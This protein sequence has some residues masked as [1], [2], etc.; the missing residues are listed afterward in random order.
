MK[1]LGMKRAIRFPKVL[2]FLAVMLM[3]A[4]RAVPAEENMAADGYIFRW[5]GGSGKA[6]IACT[7]VGEKDGRTEVTLVFSGTKGR[8]SHYDTVRVDGTDYSGNNEFTIPV[9]LN[10]NTEI[11]ARTTAMSQPHWIDYTIYVGEAGVGGNGADRSTLNDQTET[12]DTKAPDIAGLSFRS[13]IGTGN[14]ELLKLFRYADADE[15]LYTL[16]EADMK[17]RTAREDADAGEAGKTTGEDPD[18][19][20]LS[21]EEA[22]AAAAAALKKEMYDNSVVKYLIIP[23]GKEAPAGLDREVII[24]SRPLEHVYAASADALAHMEEMELADRI[25][26]VGLHEK[27]I[28]SDLIREKMTEGTIVPG[29]PADDPDYR[30]M[31]KQKVDLVI[32][33]SEIFSDEKGADPDTVMEDY[34]H[35][36]SRAVT[37]GIPV[38]MDRS[39]DEKTK[40]A[41]AEWYKLY[42]ELFGA[43]EK[44]DALCKSSIG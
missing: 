12:L 34:R 44:A 10:E 17:T 42:G 25:V 22:E 31:I 38:I 18:S 37:L 26:S 9:R 4:V 41:A 11:S 35:L 13:E 2:L 8:T 27:D 14:S 39:S 3:T 29:G 33:P 7:A 19:E 5:S 6:E 28:A 40:E 23:E 43:Q 32:L 30:S 24:I 21:G 15:N 1:R 16:I 20:E 36:V